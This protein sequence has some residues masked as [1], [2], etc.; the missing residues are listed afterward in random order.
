[1]IGVLSIPPT[2][3]Y[4]RWRRGN[5]VPT[6]AQVGTVRLFLHAQAG[7]FALLL[8]FAAAMARGYGQ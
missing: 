3:A 6:D 8:V 5:V 1:M 4:I 2:I 7:L